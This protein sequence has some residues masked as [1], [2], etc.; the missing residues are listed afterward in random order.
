MVLPERS[1]AARLYVHMYYAAYMD[2]STPYYY[3]AKPRTLSTIFTALLCLEKALSPILG[4]CSYSMEIGDLQQRGIAERP[5]K[6]R[7]RAITV[8]Y[9]T[10][11]LYDP[12]VEYWGRILETIPLFSRTNSSGVQSTDTVYSF[13]ED[14]RVAGGISPRKSETYIIWS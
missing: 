11:I 13:T 5:P 6:T 2:R 3:P 10:D 8:L 14:P 1:A 9:S 4:G 7:P 12:G